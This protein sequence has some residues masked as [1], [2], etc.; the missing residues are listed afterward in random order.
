MPADLTKKSI[1]VDD[2]QEPISTTLTELENTIEETALT[3]A[4]PGGA[5]IGRV[6]LSPEMLT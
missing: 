5:I 1:K 6:V 2:I 3:C 4:A